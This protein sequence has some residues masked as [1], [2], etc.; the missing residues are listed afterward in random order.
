[1]QKKESRQINLYVLNFTVRLPTFAVLVLRHRA[2]V[3]R[4]TVANIIESLLWND[5]LMDEAQV[6]VRKSAQAGRAFTAWLASAAKSKRKMV[7]R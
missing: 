1:M 3:Q 6:V 4:Q 7:K 2:K 5:C